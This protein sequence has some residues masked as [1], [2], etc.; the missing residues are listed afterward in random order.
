M[1]WRNREDIEFA[2]RPYL[3]R[4]GINF[5]STG[6]KRLHPEKNQVELSDGE[7]VAYDF[8]VIATG[9]KLAFDEVEGLG[10]HGG[11]TQSVCHVDHAMKSYDE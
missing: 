6:V 8:L 11:H 3:E 1:K 4:K 2:I 7:M 5:I 10:P 9:P